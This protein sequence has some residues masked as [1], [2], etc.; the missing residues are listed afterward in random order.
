MT[1]HVCGSTRVVECATWLAR[2]RVDYPESAAAR[3]FD[4]RTDEWMARSEALAPATLDRLE[5][6]FRGV[7]P[8]RRGAVGPVDRA[9]T[10]TSLFSKFYVYAIPFDRAVLRNVWAGCDGNAAGC[11]M[12][13]MRA[14][15][16]FDRFEFPRAPAGGS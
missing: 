5:Q 1:R 4:P 8:P 2:W 13:R 11:Q 15:E 6:I 12:A 10:F 14:N 16:R 9:N 3:E 7:P